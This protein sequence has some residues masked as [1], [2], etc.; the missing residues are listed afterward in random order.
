MKKDFKPKSL[1]KKQ[2]K[3]N[4]SENDNQNSKKA[5]KT[6]SVLPV[7]ESHVE[8]TPLE[9]ESHVEDTPLEKESHVEDT[10]LEKESHVEDTPLEKESHVEDTPLEKESHVEDTPLEK[11]SHVEDTPL[12]KESHVEDTPLEKESHVEDTPLEKESHVEDASTGRESSVEDSILA[13]SPPFED[14]STKRSTLESNSGKRYEAE[15]VETKQVGAKSSESSVTIGTR[16][17]RVQLVIG[18]P[19]EYRV[20]RMFMM[21]G[22]FVRRGINIYT[23]GYIDTATDVD[24]LAIKYSDSFGRV[25]AISE[26][27]SGE[28]KPLD[29][30]FWLSGLKN[31][32]NANRALLVRKPTRWNIKDFAKE[33]GVEVI[34]NDYIDK[35][36][37]ILEINKDKWLGYTDREFFVQRKNAW[38]EILRK[39]PL[40]SELFHTLSGEARFNEPFGA[41]NYYVHHMRSLTKL[42]HRTGYG[43][44][45]S[46]IKYLLADASSQLIIFFME[47]CKST[48]D[49]TSTDRKGFVSKKLTHGE[50]DPSLTQRIFDH[51]YYLSKQA[52][53]YYSG[54]PVE[55]DRSMFSMPEPDYSD[56]LIAFIEYLISRMSF[57]SHLPYSC[58]LLLAESFVKD[59][60][61]FKL[62]DNIDSTLLVRTLQGLDQ[63]IKMLVKLDCLPIQV[64]DIIGK[65]LNK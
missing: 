33:T 53:S 12:E 1:R 62:K 9:K 19:L 48:F 2:D 27:K 15:K 37:E 31:Y 11:E 44:K 56:D 34:D 60:Y 18:D 20:A 38:N 25:M 45:K 35:L 50:M 65:Q 58:D 13:N 55:M 7:K 30:I 63:Y 23:T 52:A 24:V 59:N 21:Q 41:I 28:S 57:V 54:E 64:L 29:R 32:L 16:I 42:Y 40:L 22:Y 43:D 36:E 3:I 4:V 51:A 46:L 14:A 6:V 10:P 26:C 39:D 49:L 5:T 17:P 61:H 8:D 47:I